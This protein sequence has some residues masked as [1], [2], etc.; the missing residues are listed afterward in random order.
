MTTLVMLMRRRWV[1]DLDTF[2]ADVAATLALIFL[3]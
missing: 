2:R 3:F 1:L